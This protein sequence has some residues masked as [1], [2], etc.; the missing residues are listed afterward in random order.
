MSKRE[1]LIFAVD[2]FLFHYLFYLFIY[3]GTDQHMLKSSVSKSAHFDEFFTVLWCFNHL[4]VLTGHM[5]LCVC[6]CAHSH[7]CVSLKGGCVNIKFILC[8]C[9][10]LINQMTPRPII[11]VNQ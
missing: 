3:L 7:M 10:R 1:I 4:D 6:V 2:A 8:M 5:Y 11:L 9:E